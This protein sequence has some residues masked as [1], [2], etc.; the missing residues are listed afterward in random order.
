MIKRYFLWLAKFLTTILIVLFIIPVILT[1]MVIV[2]QNQIGDVSTLGSGKLVSVIEL[3]GEIDSSKKFVKELHKQVEDERVLG[4]VV[5][6]D[7]PGGAVGPSQDMYEIIKTLKNK[8]PIVVSMG[9][10]AA[11]GGLYAALGAS[12][13]YAQPG[14]LTGSIGV[15]M[16]VPNFSKVAKQYG[17]DMLTVK[18]GKFKDVGNMFREMSDEDL[19][20]LQSAVDDV[21]EQFVQAVVEGR[22]LQRADV[23]KFA[24]GRI[25]SGSV[26]KSYG[27]VDELG[28]ILESGKAVYELAGQDLPKDGLPNLYYPEHKFEELSKILESSVGH[29]VKI[30]GIPLGNSSLSFRYQMP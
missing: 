28:G 27:L 24:D 6:V 18:S 8:K 29:F 14:T 16:Q 7:S 17:V 20:I 9:S 26:A 13:V 2:T 15:I 5:R 1:S 3:E 25:F 12:K 30:I 23:E 21:R 4:V 10:I 19:N 22:N 11:S